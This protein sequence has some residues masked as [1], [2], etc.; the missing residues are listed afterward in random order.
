MEFKN[1]PHIYNEFLEIM[2]NFKAQSINTPGVIDRVKTLFKG[3][4]KLILGFNTFLP[5]GEGFKIEL[6]PEEEAMKPPVQQ[7]HAISY[8][9]T[10][11]NRFADE[12]EI[13]RSFLKILHT[14]QKEQKGIK[15]VLEQV[16][17]PLVAQLLF[18]RVPNLYFVNSCR[19]HT[20]SPIT[21]IC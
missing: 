5:E 1:E 14:Y 15:D 9:T 13:Y 21:L 7:Q 17:A 6:S 10:I 2:K 16:I 3:Y 19:C 18:I 8:V 4:N 12:P 11:R 20:Y